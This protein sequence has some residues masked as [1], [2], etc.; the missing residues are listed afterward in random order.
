[1]ARPNPTQVLDLL[2]KFIEHLVLECQWPPDKIHLFGFGQGGS[3]AAELG[4]RWWKVRSTQHSDSR[5]GSIVS[6]GGPLLSYPTP[7][8]PCPTPVLVYHRL[9]SETTKLSLGDLR[10]FNKGYEGVQE[11]QGAGGDGMPRSK[12]DWEPIMRFWSVNLSTRNS[13][14][15]YE[16][17][18]GVDSSS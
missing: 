15:L 16:V 12:E 6:V 17:I 11:V 1:M 10:A 4:L 9:V 8:S 18:G 14:G 7:S 5:L 3:V 13:P 2:G